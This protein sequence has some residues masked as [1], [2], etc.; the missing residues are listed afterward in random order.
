MHDRSDEDAR[1]K[2]VAASQLIDTAPEEIYDGLTMLA[3]QLCGA[4][5]AL[6]GFVEEERYW[7]KS[8]YRWNLA[9]LPREMSFCSHVVASGDPVVVPDTLAD[10]RFAN[11]PL[12]TSEPHI[13]F[14]AAVPL[15][16]SDGHAIGALE[17]FDRAPRTLSDAQLQ[18]LRLLAQQ[19]AAH[20][21][22]RRRLFESKE[23]E[24]EI[25]EL[26]EAVEESEE[27]F[28]DLF[29]TVDDLI[30]TMR[31]DGRL[32]H[33]NTACSS[34]LGYQEI[35][36]RPI[37]EF[38][39]PRERED[40]RIAFDRVVNSGQRER[41]E[42]TFTTVGGA[43]LIADGVLIPKVVDGYT[44]LTRIIF[45]DITDRKQ[46]EIELGKARDAALESAR[47][48]A[49]FLANVSHEIRTPMHGII[50]M[51]GLLLDSELT[52]EQR[53]FALSARTS[54]DA[55]LTI[56]NNILHV[57]RLESGQLS[58]SMADFDL[59]TTIERVVEV[60]QIAA[61]EKNLRLTA[62]YDPDLPTIVRGD[63]GR[64]RQVLSNILGNA[65]KFTEHGSV[66]VKVTV[67]NETETHQLVRVTVSDSGPGISPEVRH[68]L[69]QSFTQLDGSAKRQHEGV[70]LGL[71]IAK[72]LVELMGG[73][74]DVESTPGQGSDFWFTV[75][76]EKR[77]ASKL[78]VA[79]SRLAFPGAR[80]LIVDAS[81]TNR[82]LVVHFVTTWGMRSRTATNGAEAIERLRA[83]AALG[84]PYRAVIVDYHMANMNGAQMART[85]KAD[86]TI[87]STGIVL[88]T[89]LGEP[90]DDATLRAAGVSAY[91]AKP[92]DKSEL[93]DC[94]T[95]AMAKDLI[96]GNEATLKFASP[97]PVS[98]AA[99]A[100]VD[101]EKR[102]QL[103][104]LLAE[105]KPLNQKLTLS[106]L[107]SLGYSARAVA[108]GN[109]VL[110]AMREASFDLI[111]MDC[112][113]PLMDGYET[114]MEIRKREGDARRTRII[115]MTANALE[116][117]REKCLAAGMDDYLSKPTRREELDA[118]LNRWFGEP[119]R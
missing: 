20:V 96:A 62:Q 72:Q 64:F 97:E 3:A 18:A 34:V 30:M 82:K 102:Q 37:L 92:V 107:Q 56:M 27:R 71:S 28:R 17:V 105:D 108:N 101:P 6:L 14:Y 95:A 91:L 5:V 90:L 38:I 113:M 51:I 7:V 70:G 88:M 45:R 104:I 46:T 86:P 99:G 87:G 13:R 65:V 61:Q 9:H 57:S 109:E 24:A 73:V 39:H 119:V 103:K 118:A 94:L 52:S 75:P 67:D 4:P 106:Q 74:I 47:L 48:K 84:D 100:A 49:Q 12:V 29:D 76:F 11:N 83:E 15:R 77:V 54:A 93:F 69:F 23:R 31:S 115:A 58:V 1:L 44:V 8:R 60:M 112:Q 117:D 33:A 53:E 110:D 42:T 98:R 63:P 81:E 66:N 35:T 26:R 41:V 68:H 114:T 85:I 36:G 78:A 2:A 55:L 40:F 50:G 22:A 21:S 32:L 16:S 116:G 111:L 43:N 59:M 79:G 89:Q 80:V 19:A 10:P 25:A